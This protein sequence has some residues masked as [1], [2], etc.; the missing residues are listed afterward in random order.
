MKKI[1]PLFV[2]FLFALESQAQVMFVNRFEIESKFQDNNFTIIPRQGGLVG[3]RI[4][5]DK[6][7]NLKSKFQYFLT[8]YELVS[9]TFRE[10]AVKDFYD[11][12]GYD[13]EGDFLYILLQ[14]GEA[15]S[16][17]YMIEIDLKNDLAK[18]IDLTNIYTLELKEFFVV[19]RNAVFMGLSD[20]RPVVQ[21]LDI[22]ANNVYTVQGIYF[23]DTNILQIKKESELGTI[24]V[25]VSR[26]DRLK[27]KQL[28]LNTYDEKGNKVREVVIDQLQDPAFELVEGLMT[29][30]EQYQQSLVGTYGYRKREA[31]QGIYQA[32]INEFGEYDIRYYTLEN[33]PNFF[34]YLNEKQREKKLTELERSFS[35]GKIPSIKPVF[36]TREVIPT[37]DGYL[38]YSDHF[39]ANNPRYIPRDGVYANESYRNNI[40]RMYMDGM[41]YMPGYGMPGY[42]FNRYGAIGWQQG[43]YKFVSA[44][45]LYLSNT[46]EVIWDNA[47]DLNNRLLSY[48]SKYGE[49]SFN[50]EKLHY[51]YLD[52][53][54]I[55]MS[56]IKN[57]EKIF[58]NQS[59]EIKLINEEERLRETQEN[60]LNLTWWFM[61][62]FL[63]SGKQKVR[64]V[65]EDGKEAIK[66]VFFL[67]K[68]KV[69]GDQFDPEAE[70]T[71]KESSASN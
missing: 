12:L 55:Y 14:K 25:L 33:F 13:L 63:L 4:Q 51:L 56:Y 9:D 8:D 31:Y 2:L 52:G 50:G 60:S 20:L 1:I 68:I 62:Y 47:L 11:L 35:K 27:N 36:S 53:L 6:G 67:T 29:P 59:Y 26:R 48:S 58:E 17:R 37:G 70:K 57:G 44:H 38:I 16:D 34:N 40:N 19:N 21:I 69:D 49:I 65:G 32:F 22:E 3:F 43:E 28:V 41:G 39:L 5:P 64:Y 46:G 54:N 23:K 30:I 45:M 42:P 66:E 10:I 61:D 7:F 24:D 71:E 18:E 15:I